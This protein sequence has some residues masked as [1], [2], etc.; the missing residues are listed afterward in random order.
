MLSAGVVVAPKK[1]M[2]LPGARGGIAAGGM[3]GV[4]LDVGACLALHRTCL[5]TFFESPVC[6]RRVFADVACGGGAL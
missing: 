1:G 5:L 2:S 3:V 6:R 4:C